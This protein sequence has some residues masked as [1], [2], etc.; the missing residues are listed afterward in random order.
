MNTNIPLGQISTFRV[1]GLDR[2][3]KRFVL[4]SSNYNYVMMINLWQGSVWAV[5]ENGKKKLLKRV[6]N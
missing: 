2:N 5:L 4:E 1:T 6:S 3:N